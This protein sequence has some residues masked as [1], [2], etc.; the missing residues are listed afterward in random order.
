MKITYWKL[1]LSIA[2]GIVL[3]TIL[4]NALTPLL[5]RLLALL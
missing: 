5:K 4:E 2:L 1:T 3:A